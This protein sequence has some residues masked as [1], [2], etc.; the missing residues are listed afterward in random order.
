MKA[1]ITILSLSSLACFGQNKVMDYVNEHL[2][3]RVGDGCCFDLPMLALRLDHETMYQLLLDGDIGFICADKIDR[4]DIQ[5]GDIIMYDD[6]TDKHG[7]TIQGHTGIVYKII[8]SRT[9]VIA[10]QNHGE[11]ADNIDTIKCGGY[12]APVYVHSRVRLTTLYLSR[13]NKKEFI[14]DHLVFL[15]VA[16]PPAKYFSLGSFVNPK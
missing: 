12:Y 6:A 7:N 9:V 2:G 1:L 10:E 14:E 15:R 5:P 4:K 11:E 13:Y 16:Y 3:D 8:N